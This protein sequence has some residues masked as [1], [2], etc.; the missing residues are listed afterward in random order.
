[1]AVGSNG[2]C[3]IQSEASS[4]NRPALSHLSWMPSREHHGGSQA[5]RRLGL[6]PSLEGKQDVM[7][8]WA[9]SPA[10]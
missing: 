10:H 5:D 8:M 3:L 6:P 7:E 1:M 4:P 2:V 9:E